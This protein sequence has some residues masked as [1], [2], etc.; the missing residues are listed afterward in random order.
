MNQRQHNKISPESCVNHST[1]VQRPASTQNRDLSHQFL[2]RLFAMSLYARSGELT[3]PLSH[4]PEPV[5]DD[6]GHQ[7]ILVRY[8]D[9]GVQKNFFFGTPLTPQQIEAANKEWY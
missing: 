8:L 3:A 6:D 7:T 2:P 9:Q 5:Y 4:I 1:A